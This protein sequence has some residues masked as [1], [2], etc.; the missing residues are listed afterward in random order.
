[1]VLSGPRKTSMVASMISQTSHFGI[2]GG[3]APST[4]IAQG[5]KRFR[6]RRAR[7]RQTIPLMPGP[8]LAFMREHGLLSVNPAGSGGVGL[9]KVLVDRSMGPCNCG[10]GESD[11]GG[12]SKIAENGGEIG[13]TNDL[14]QDNSGELELDLALGSY[15]KS[16]PPPMYT[17][18]E[19]GPGGFE[20]KDCPPNSKY[21]DA[22]GCYPENCTPQGNCRGKT[23]DMGPSQGGVFC[24]GTYPWQTPPWDQCY[25]GQR[26][27]GDWY[28]FSNAGPG[29]P[30]PIHRPND[31][32]DL[33]S[34]GKFIWRNHYLS[35]DDAACGCMDCTEWNY[36]AATV[37]PATGKPKTIHANT[38]FEEQLAEPPQ[39][40]LYANHPKPLRKELRVDSPY[41]GTFWLLELMPGGS[42]AQGAIGSDGPGANPGTWAFYFGGADMDVVV[43]YQPASEFSDN[44]PYKW[45]PMAF[46]LAPGSTHVIAYASKPVAAYPVQS[47]DN[48]RFDFKMSGIRDPTYWK[49]KLKVNLDGRPP[50]EIV[51]S[52][53]ADN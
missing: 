42:G 33:N 20:Q 21:Y 3:L 1:M 47:N 39:G 37:D 51:V 11:G 49:N 48:V 14:G 22:Q 24:P 28:P 13:G 45:L 35:C 5:V 26:A 46:V 52:I 7:N 9:T 4:N 43:Q 19:P 23:K 50:D 31:P 27:N 8:G 38:G 17:L 2:M 18:F 15:P 44:P 36:K 25:W 32:S 10:S 29:L 40:F 16:L 34:N 12:S 30:L 53:D 6:L 41:A